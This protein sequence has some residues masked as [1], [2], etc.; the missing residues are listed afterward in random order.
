MGSTFDVTF[1]CVLS[2]GNPDTVNTEK[3][4]HH[5][6]QW[7]VSNWILYQ[8]TSALN[9]THQPKT[10]CVSVI[11]DILITTDHQHHNFWKQ[12]EKIDI[13][14]VECVTSYGEQMEYLYWLKWSDVLLFHW[15]RAG[16]SYIKDVIDAILKPFETFF[17]FL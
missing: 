8:D 13:I 6:I 7:N 1:Q 11:N 5:L 14:P 15:H 17:D 16:N 3:Y 2:C 10:V 12:L 9:K 4:H